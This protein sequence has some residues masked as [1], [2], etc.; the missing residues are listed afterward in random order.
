MDPHA[1]WFSS[2]PGT[3]QLVGILS[4]EL[5]FG[6]VGM[7]V[8]QH[9]IGAVMVILFLLAGAA[10]SSR[11]FKSTPVPPR[12][13]GLTLIYDG[14]LGGCA[15]LCKDL[16][17]TN[18]W[19]RYFPLI[20]TL[21]LFILFSN[22]LGL[23]PGFVPPT[24]NLETT[25]VCAVIVFVYYNFHGL[26]RNGIAHIAHMANP[27]GE[28]WTWVL[29]PMMFPIEI[30]GHLARPLSLA[31]RLRGNMVGDHAVIAAFAGIL[32]VILPLPFLLLGLLIC[33]LQ[34]YVFCMLT[35]IYIGMAVE[36]QKH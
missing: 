14:V 19:R 5:I 11:Y 21:G 22:L 30:V 20:S 1:S 33:C 34:A 25:A 7:V 12:R 17:G 26:R 8:I 32:P 31:L 10:R 36:D 24:N 29:A 3:E 27:A 15:S 2:F 23:I 35:A 13:F 9:L 16:I 28:R 6:D 4:Q 18:E